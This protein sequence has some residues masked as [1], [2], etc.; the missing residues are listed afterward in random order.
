MVP[1]I[2]I[3]ANVNLIN[4]IAGQAARCLRHRCWRTFGEQRA[5][6]ASVAKDVHG[7][8]LPLL[9]EECK[10]TMLATGKTR[11]HREK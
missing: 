5:A 7:V 6:Y 4:L 9:L 2:R 1:H 10:L 11:D 8:L 3:T